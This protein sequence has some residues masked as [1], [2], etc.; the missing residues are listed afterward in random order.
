[1]REDLV[2]TTAP[3]EEPLDINDLKDHL[4]VTGD[5]QDSQIS[6]MGKSARQFAERYQ[7][8]SFLTQ[9]WTLW[10]D[11]FP[12]KDFVKLRRGPVQSITHIKYYDTDDNASTLATTEYMLDASDRVVL[13][14]GKTWPADTLRPAKAVEIQYDAGFDSID[15]LLAERGYVVE[16]VKQ[17]VTHLYENREPVVVG[18]TANDVPLS[19]LM[20]LDADRRVFV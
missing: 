5:V 8:A 13:R 1:M 7:D 16:A 19:A 20:L 17:I 14:Y 10:L 12:Y 4:R 6:A 2:L 15:S 11:R 18:L 9:T 3:D